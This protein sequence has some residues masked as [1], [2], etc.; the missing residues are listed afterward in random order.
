MAI[1]RNP[2]EFLFVLGCSKMCLGVVQARAMHRFFI[3]S[4]FLPFHL[5][6]VDTRTHTHTH[7]R[8][9]IHTHA[10]THP[11]THTHTR[12]HTRTPTHTRAH[13]QTHTGS[14]IQHY[15]VVKKKKRNISFHILPKSMQEA[16]KKKHKNT[17]SNNWQEKR[18]YMYIKKWTGNCIKLQG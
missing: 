6:K 15:G 5:R 3:P 12:T 11:H 1:R 16:I 8:T 7:T 17:R 9:H 14:H 10:H 18:W 2:E 4:F 13:T